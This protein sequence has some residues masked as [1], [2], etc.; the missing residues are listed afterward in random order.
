MT[1]VKATSEEWQMWELDNSGLK[2]GGKPSKD[3]TSYEKYR[4][5]SRRCNFKWKGI[6]QMNPLNK[7]KV[8]KIMA[9]KNMGKN[10]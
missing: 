8:E 5:E 10:N 7:S 6:R 4:M 1:A 2:M 9:V 3:K